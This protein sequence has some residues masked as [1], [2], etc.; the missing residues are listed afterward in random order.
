MS[1][2]FLLVKKEKLYI[3]G[4]GFRRFSYCGSDHWRSRHACDLGH[5]TR[6]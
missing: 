4:G 2:F 5:T 6:Q 3:L 1:K